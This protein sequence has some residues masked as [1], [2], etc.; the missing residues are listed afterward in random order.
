MTHFRSILLLFLIA[1]APTSKPRPKPTF[2]VVVRE[3]IKKSLDDLQSSA[4]FPAAEAQ[5]QKIFDQTIAY[6]LPKD[7]DVIRDA[8]YALRL[9]HQLQS[10]CIVG[11][12]DHVGV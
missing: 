8:D 3:Q 1:A 12:A 7:A 6:S 2:P 4:D 10:E 11:V 9:V 5:L